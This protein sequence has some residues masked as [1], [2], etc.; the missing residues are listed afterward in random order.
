MPKRSGYVKKKKP[1]G[2]SG[3]LKRSL[4]ANVWAEERYQKGKELYQVR[5][6]A[7]KAAGDAAVAHHIKKKGWQK[8]NRNTNPYGKGYSP[9]KKEVKPQS[10]LINRRK[11]KKLLPLVS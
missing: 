1:L 9:P 7:E 4:Q 6:K 8:Y 11:G 3:K 10:K 5:R 2:I